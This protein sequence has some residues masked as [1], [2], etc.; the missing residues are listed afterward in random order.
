MSWSSFITLIFTR[1]IDL[2]LFMVFK[3]TWNLSWKIPNFVKMILFNTNR[4]SKKL[5]ASIV[6]FFKTNPLFSYIRELLQLLPSR[7]T[8]LISITSFKSHQTTA[9]A[10]VRICCSRIKASIGKFSCTR[11]TW[12]SSKLWMKRQF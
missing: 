7:W 3:F 5:G 10:K 2:F 1:K 8:P 11:I 9:K 6:N 4:I 12:F